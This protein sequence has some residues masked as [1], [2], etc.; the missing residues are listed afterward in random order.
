M[1]FSWYQKARISRTS[2]TQIINFSALSQS[3]FWTGQV[4]W[5][6][7]DE[8][9][10]IM[11][12]MECSRRFWNQ[13]DRL[14]SVVSQ[15]I[16]AREKDICGRN[17]R[18]SGQEKFPQD[19]QSAPE[20]YPTNYPSKCDNSDIGTKEE[21]RGF[22]I[23]EILSIPSS[24]EYCDWS[25]LP[26]NLPIRNNM[27][28][29]NGVKAAMDLEEDTTIK[30]LIGEDGNL[31]DVIEQAETGL[32][33][34]FLDYFLD[35]GAAPEDPLCHLLNQICKENT[36]EKEN[37]ENM[38]P[39]GNRLNGQQSYNSVSFGHYPEQQAASTIGPIRQTEKKR[40]IS[41]PYEIGAPG[42]ADVIRDITAE[43]KIAWTLQWPTPS[44]RKELL[45]M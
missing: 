10:K 12:R 25:S 1:L 22:D 5:F 21:I 9:L 27:N 8:A 6:N 16:A 19:F 14:E 3:I 18:G 29:A 13:R 34:G 15:R 7:V 31:E 28:T 30:E 36:D 26:K 17:R 4:S 40:S 44:T 41:K 39:F 42:H 32:L 38:D 24:K 11:V 23:D 37:K 20:T 2:E 45:E 33:D 43:S 35:D